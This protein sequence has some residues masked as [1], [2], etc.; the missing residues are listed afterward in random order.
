MPFEYLVNYIPRMDMWVSFMHGERYYFGRKHYCN[1]TAEIY[2][3][4]SCPPDYTGTWST[5]DVNRREDFWREMEPNNL[6]VLFMTWNPQDKVS[7]PLYPLLDNMGLIRLSFDTREGYPTTTITLLSSSIS[8]P[9]SIG[10][11][12]H[13]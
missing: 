5:E 1:A 3:H 11:E 10:R 9:T 7:I 8:H 13:E 6:K 2:N 12:Y 4:A